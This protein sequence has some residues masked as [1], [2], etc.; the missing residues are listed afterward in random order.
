MDTQFLGVPEISAVVFFGLA[1]ASL[2]TAF[3]GAVTATAG[4]LLLLGIL[5]LVFPPAVLIPVHTVVQLGDNASRVVMLRRYILRGTLL[6]FFLGAAAGA[7]AGAQIFVTLPTAVLQGFLGAFI[8]LF[9]WMPRFARTGSTR[10]RFAVVGF[11]ATFLG[12]F[13]SATGSIVAPFVASASPERR[14][15]VA[16]FSALMLIVHLCKIVA[17]GLLGMALADYLPLMAA[18]IATATL[19]NWLGGRILNRMP[20]RAFRQVFRVLMTLLALRLL[21][22][23]AADAGLI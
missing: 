7:A 19:G 11:A 9:T 17:F 1:L 23:A 22:R 10:N 2:C 20:E 13:V 21:W 14:N 8:I 12:I 15:H 5:A 6:P 18:M 4:G 3:I 16:T